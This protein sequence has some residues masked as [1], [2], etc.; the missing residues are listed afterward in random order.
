MK[1]PR[2][3]M[4]REYGN[5]VDLDPEARYVELGRMLYCRSYIPYG[6]EIRD[7]MRGRDSYEEV[8]KEVASF[9]LNYLQEEEDAYR[10]A[11]VFDGFEP[12]FEE[13]IPRF[14]LEER[15]KVRTIE[16]DRS[17]DRPKLYDWA[18]DDDVVD[19]D[20]TPPSP[21]RQPSP[22]GPTLP[23]VH[24]HSSDSSVLPP[25]VYGIDESAA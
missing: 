14:W 18:T 5:S 10:Y 8:A 4:A 7:R 6:R 15:E 22:K 1:K 25:S 24:T 16:R 13:L 9:V 2:S 21:L 23:S 20:P 3:Q 12:F 17:K 19:P 11:V